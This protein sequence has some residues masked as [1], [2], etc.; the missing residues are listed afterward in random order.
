ML[1][2]YVEI[3]QRLPR[4]V[5]NY[6]YP[7]INIGLTEYPKVSRVLGLVEYIKLTDRLLGDKIDGSSKRLESRY[8]N[9]II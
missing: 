3:P 7:N 6:R 5:Q 4:R 9:G 1:F 8:C 2:T